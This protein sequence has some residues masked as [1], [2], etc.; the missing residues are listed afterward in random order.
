MFRRVTASRC[1][2]GL[3]VKVRRA[4]APDSDQ[5]RCEGRGMAS[6][7][8]KPVT[9]ITGASAGIGASLARV[10]ARNGHE[11]ALVSRREKEMTLLATE[12]AVSAKHRPIVIPQDLQRSDAPARIAHELLSRGLE[13]AIVVNN[14]GFG[15][16]GPA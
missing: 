5:F 14:A 16:H 9:V 13:P 6:S 2:S 3:P 15:L 8:F 10:F 4:A 7:I 12:I 1:A 11:I